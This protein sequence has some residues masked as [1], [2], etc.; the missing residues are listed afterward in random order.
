VKKWPWNLRKM[1][2]KWCNG[3]STVVSNFFFKCTHQIFIHH[4]QSGS[5][6]KPSYIFLCPSLNSRTQL[7]TIELL[8]ACSPYK[9]QSWRISACFMVFTFKKLITDHISY[10]VGFSIFL[11]IIN[12]TQCVDTVRMSVNCVRAL[13]QNQ[14][15]QCTRTP[16]WP[17]RCSSNIIKW[18]LFSGKPAYM[19]TLC[20]LIAAYWQFVIM[21]AELKKELGM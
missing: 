14:Q 9:S 19:V 1:Q 20:L 18:N 15:T 10:A 4:R 8:M 6:H 12:T 13:P 3:E 11:N 17:Q 16:S 21:L 7:R 5:L 2:G